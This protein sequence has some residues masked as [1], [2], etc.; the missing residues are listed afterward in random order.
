MIY[1][2]SVDLSTRGFAVASAAS[3][4]I[5]SSASQYHGIVVADTA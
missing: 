3:A 1:A 4:A 2:P 5:A